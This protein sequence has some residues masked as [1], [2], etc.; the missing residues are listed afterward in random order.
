MEEKEEF[1]QEK[2]GFIEKASV[3]LESEKEKFDQV[4]EFTYIKKFQCQFLCPLLAFIA[5]WK[6]V[7]EDYLK[8]LINHQGKKSTL[9]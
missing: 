5:L 3:E 9:K 1:S 8:T 4:I 2:A 7:I 6:N